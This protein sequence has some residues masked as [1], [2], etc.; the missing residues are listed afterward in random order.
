MKNASD[1]SR[2]GKWHFA[3][4]LQMFMTG[5][6]FRTRSHVDTTILSHGA[7]LLAKRNANMGSWGGI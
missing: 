4:F 2:G 6:A 3:F 1:G 7:M 5:R